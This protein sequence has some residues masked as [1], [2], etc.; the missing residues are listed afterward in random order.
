MIFYLVGVFVFVF[1]FITS[2][3]KDEVS[4]PKVVVV[5]LVSETITFY[6]KLKVIDISGMSIFCIFVD[7]RTESISFVEFKS[8][9]EK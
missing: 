8:S 1:V 5:F 2:A 9:K 7:F 6:Q 4:K 3:E